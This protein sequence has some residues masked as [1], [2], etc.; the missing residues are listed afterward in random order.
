MGTNWITQGGTTA[1]VTASA[2][3]RSQA[4]S[5]SATAPPAYANQAQVAAQTMT[6]ANANTAITAGGVTGAGTVTSVTGTATTTGG[7]LGGTGGGS[8]AGSS[9]TPTSSPT[10]SPTPTPSGSGDDDDWPGY[11]I[12]LV[13]ICTLLLLAGIGLIGFAATRKKAAP[14]QSSSSDAP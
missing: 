12:A 14:A 7:N 4:V 6:A 10:S 13:V 1:S 9:N 3:R 8:P 5:Y 11:G 2:S